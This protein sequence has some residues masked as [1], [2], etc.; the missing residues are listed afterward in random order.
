MA[1]LTLAADIAWRFGANEALARG[2]ATLEPADLLI[3]I[4]A[5][6]KV[7]SPELAE[8]MKITEYGLSTVRVEWQETLKAVSATGVSPAALRREIRAQLPKREAAHASGEKPKVSRSEV[9]KAVFAKAGELAQATGSDVAGIRYLLYA[10]IDGTPLDMPDQLYKRIERMKP[11]LAELVRQPLHTSINTI[12]EGYVS[13]HAIA[14]T[15]DRR[16]AKA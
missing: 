7:F 6:E 14:P 10:L 13:E 12:E 11:P 2:S 16:R 1:T 5:I 4:L 9:C 8:R 15:I 3:G